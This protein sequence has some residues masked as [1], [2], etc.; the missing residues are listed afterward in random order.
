MHNGPL[1]AIKRAV[2][3]YK[4]TN[5]NDKNCNLSTVI[6]ATHQ[7]LQNHKMVILLSITLTFR[8]FETADKDKYRNNLILTTNLLIMQAV[9]R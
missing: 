7:K 9:Y 8:R 6:T 5:I 4:I 3:D 1:S 2:I